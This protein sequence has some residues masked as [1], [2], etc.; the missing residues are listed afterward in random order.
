MPDINKDDALSE[1]KEIVLST[2]SF[3]VKKRNESIFQ[4][5]SV[6]I[7]KKELKKEEEDIL[8][9]KRMLKIK[10]NQELDKHK[11]ILTKEDLSIFIEEEDNDPNS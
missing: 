10:I 6:R 1:K 8:N 7:R 2:L 11:N 3:L 4:L 9:R 5:S